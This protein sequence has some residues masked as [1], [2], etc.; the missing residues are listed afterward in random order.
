MTGKTLASPRFPDDSNRTNTIELLQRNYS[1]EG[2]VPTNTTLGIVATNAKLT[3]EQVNKVAA[4]AHDGMA[5]AI[6]PS[7]TMY[8]GDTIFALSLGDKTGDVSIIG[9]V[10]AELTSEAIRRAIIHAETLAGV[11]SIKDI[12]GGTAC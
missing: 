7:H 5:R 12:E 11:P 3:K 4:M 2:F 1:N 10:A 6:N 8:D 9:A